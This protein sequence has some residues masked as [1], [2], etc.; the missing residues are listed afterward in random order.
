MKK[1]NSEYDNYKNTDTDINPLV[2]DNNNAIINQDTTNNYEVINCNIRY[3]KKDYKIGKIITLTNKEYDNLS[4][5]QKYL[6]RI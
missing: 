3:N 1:Y 4:K 6:K 5:S 2:S